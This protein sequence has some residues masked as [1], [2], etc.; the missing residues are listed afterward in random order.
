MEQKVKFTCDGEQLYKALL[1]VTKEF[2]GRKWVYFKTC[3]AEQKLYLDNIVGIPC[4]DFS[5]D[6]V[7]FELWRGEIKKYIRI[8]RGDKLRF[9][10]EDLELQINTTSLVLSSM[11]QTFPV[12]PWANKKKSSCNPKGESTVM[13]KDDGNDGIKG[14]TKTKDSVEKQLREEIIKPYLDRI[15]ELEKQLKE[16]IEEEQALLNI[17]YLEQQKRNGAMAEYEEPNEKLGAESGEHKKFDDD[18]R[19]ALLAQL[20]DMPKERKRIN[21]Q[22]DDYVWKATK[23]MDQLKDQI[24]TLEKRLNVQ[25]WVIL[26]LGI[27]WIISIIYLLA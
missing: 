22:L 2:K 1:E 26:I 25:K 27:G 6:D 18:E 8:E 4:Y 10:V 16:H 7:A 12:E 11:A 15:A 19:A 3:F 23:K 9:E 24:K 21:K 17:V 20:N 13:E 14:K 5:G